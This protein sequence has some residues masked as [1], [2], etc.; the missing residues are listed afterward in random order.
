MSRATKN[1]NIQ[2]FWE[3]LYSALQNS[4]LD[5]RDPN[6]SFTELTHILKE[7]VDKHVSLVKLSRIQMKLKSKP[8]LTKGIIKSINTINGLFNSCFKLKKTHAVNNYRT[9]LKM[10]KKVMKHAKQSYYQIEIKK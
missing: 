10:L 8:W 1:F 5:A 2:D 6:K 3:E 7:M 9:Y 4:K